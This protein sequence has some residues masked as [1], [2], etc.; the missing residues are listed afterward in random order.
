MVIASHPTIEE[1]IINFLAKVNPNI[2]GEKI[3]D[4]KIPELLLLITDSVGEKNHHILS[5]V[6]EV[7]SKIARTR[8]GAEQIVEANGVRIISRLLPYCSDDHSSAIVFGSQV[9]ASLAQIDE[10]KLAISNIA[11]PCMIKVFEKIGR[12]EENNNVSP[13]IA[14]LFI[15]L[16]VFAIYNDANKVII[17]S[18]SIPRISKTIVEHYGNDIN[19]LGSCAT[20]IANVSYKRL[21][22]THQLLT[23]NIMGTLTQTCIEKLTVDVHEK[24]IERILVAIANVCN[25]Q[26]N[27]AL[28]YS[29]DGTV[30][31]VVHL[32]QQSD[33]PSIIRDAAIACTSMCFESEVARRHYCH[34]ECIEALIDIVLRL[35]MYDET[36]ED[37]EESKAA[38][39][40]TWALIALTMDPTAS[41][42]FENILHDFESL[43]QLYL[44]TDSETVLEAGSMFVSIL[45][46]STE[47]KKTLASEGRRSFI[48]NQGGDQ[49]IQRCMSNVYF[50]DEA[51]C[52]SWLLQSILILDSE[53]NEIKK[54]NKLSA[55]DCFSQFDLYRLIEPHNLI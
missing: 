27:S 18:S 55:A 39:A 16:S 48:E 44:Q 21:C 50:C 37:K 38:E 19:I 1:A 54:F 15:T 51:L 42:K 3:L 17:S 31:F 46:P 52:P 23:S 9:L 8:L 45:L 10:A 28:M 26:E 25:S 20:M 2:E 29:I 33:K 32:L 14:E 53:I 11:M 4:Y 40:A 24:D 6:L 22:S 43:L 34:K 12:L 36:I 30:D 49:I 13:C 41:H 35:G 5:K 7:L 47:T